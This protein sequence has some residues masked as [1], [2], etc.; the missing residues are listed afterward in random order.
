MKKTI[1]FATLAVLV[2]NIL[3]GLLLSSYHTFNM[4]ATSL[5]IVLTTTLMYITEYITMK[6]AFRVS[7]PFVFAFL[8]LVM[9]LLMLFSKPQLQDNWCVIVSLVLLSFEVLVLYVTHRVSKTIK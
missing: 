7:L 9:F 2:V 6:D 5:V 1:L 3:A 4:L 8:G